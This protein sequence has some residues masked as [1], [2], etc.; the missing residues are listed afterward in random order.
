[1]VY[2]EDCIVEKRKTFPPPTPHLAKRLNVDARCA[3]E[4]RTRTFDPATQFVLVK[5]ESKI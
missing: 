5:G 1:M 3:K 4:I 2:G